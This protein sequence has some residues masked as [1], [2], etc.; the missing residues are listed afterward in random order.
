MEELGG[1]YDVDDDIQRLGL[2][3]QQELILAL[4]RHIS[5]DKHKILYNYKVAHVRG[6][7]EC[8]SEQSLEATMKRLKAA[9]YFKP[10]KP[11]KQGRYWGWERL[12]VDLDGKHTAQ[13][14]DMKEENNDAITSDGKE[15][16]M[17]EPTKSDEPEATVGEEKSYDERYPAMRAFMETVEK[18]SAENRR[19]QI[20][21]QSEEINQSEEERINLILDAI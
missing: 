16:D 21:E 12:C 11:V 7:F 3:A 10:S 18:E 4:L 1:Y 5:K 2:S 13:E 6:Y 14:D 9:G 17:K 15:G 19:E 20:T 8:M